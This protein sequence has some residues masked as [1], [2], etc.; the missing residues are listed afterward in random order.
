VRSCSKAN[1]ESPN[2]GPARSPASGRR[3]E[4]VQVPEPVINQQ[5][6]GMSSRVAKG[7]TSDAGRR[8]IVALASATQS[9][10]ATQAMNAPW[11]KASGAEATPSTG[12]LRRQSHL[13][14][15]GEYLVPPLSVDRL[16][17]GTS[18][19]SLRV[20]ARWERAASAK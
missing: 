17:S 20:L 2:S 5:A 9:V 14:D 16:C 18:C 1:T 6:V 7:W 15:V 4:P 12:R 8:T 19:E 10:E 13:G 11:P 3:A